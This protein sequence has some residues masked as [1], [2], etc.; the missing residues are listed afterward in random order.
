MQEIFSAMLEEI[1]SN[2]CTGGAAKRRGK[3]GSAE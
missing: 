1:S 2:E 3:K